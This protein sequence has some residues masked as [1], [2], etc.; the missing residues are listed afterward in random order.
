MAARPMR[1]LVN[2]LGASFPRAKHRYYEKP[3][4]AEEET[5]LLFDRLLYRQRS[6]NAEENCPSTA[7]ATAMYT[8][9]ECQQ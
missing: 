6:F 1:P 4:T 8:V 5:P 2:S 3:A 9:H 7:P